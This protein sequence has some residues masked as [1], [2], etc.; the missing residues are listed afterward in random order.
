MKRCLFILYA[1]SAMVSVSHAQDYDYDI[2]FDSNRNAM[3]HGKF[4]SGENTLTLDMSGIKTGGLHFLNVI[5]YDELGEMGKWSCI[6]FIVPEGWPNTT[7]ASF[8]EYWVY[9]YDSKPTRIP[10][11]GT[12]YQ[13]DID[14]SKMSYGLHFLNVRCFNEVGEAGPWKQIAFYISNFLFDKEPLCY[15]YWIDNGE[16]QTCYDYYPGMVSFPVSLEDIT[17]GQHTFYYRVCYSEDP[18]VEGAEFSTTQSFKF[19]VP[20]LFGDVNGD[21]KVTITDAVAIV[22]YILGQPSSDF[23]IRVADVNNDTKV[24]ITDAVAV[25]NIILNKTGGS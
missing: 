6:P 16:V 2:W 3:T 20:L 25:V 24:T 12:A 13:L 4:T 18:N 7:N 5:P 1:F 8:L 11:D 21:K 15:Q 10:Y 9:G 14:V 23:D 22:N 17:V 19:D